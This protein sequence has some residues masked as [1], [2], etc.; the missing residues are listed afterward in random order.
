MKFRLKGMRPLP[1]F[2]PIQTVFD[3]EFTKL[4]NSTDLNPRIVFHK[5]MFNWRQG[6]F[7]TGIIFQRHKSIILILC[8][9]VL[10][11][12][13]SDIRDRLHG[14]SEDKM[15]GYHYHKYVSKFVVDLLNGWSIDCS[16]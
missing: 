4:I 7:F 15:T 13:L 2:N 10:Q 6:I 12:D 1:L 9:F 16:L 11:F 3:E 8:D 14:L 5:Y